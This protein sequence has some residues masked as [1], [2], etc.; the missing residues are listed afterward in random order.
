M[1]EYIHA[2]HSQQTT[3][4]DAAN[5]TIA[6]LKQELEGTSAKLLEQLHEVEVLT[7]LYTEAKAKIE[8]RNR[9]LTEL[10]MMLETERDSKKAAAAAWQRFMDTHEQ[11]LNFGENDD[12]HELC[13]QLGVELTKQHEIE[14]TIKVCVTATL[15]RDEDPDEYANDIHIHTLRLQDG[16][17]NQTTYVS[18]DICNREVIED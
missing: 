7:E 9:E 17:H 11:Y 15:M 18:A 2:N 12:I 8:R 14:L 6:E 4:S 13:K 1:S 16:Y 10:E 5:Q 3:N